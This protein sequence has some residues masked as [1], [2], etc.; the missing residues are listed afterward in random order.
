MGQGRRKRGLGPA[1]NDAFSQV[2]WRFAGGDSVSALRM[3]SGGMIFDQQ[4][5]LSVAF[6]DSPTKAFTSA[7]PSLLSEFT[8]VGVLFSAVDPLNPGGK[9]GPSGRQPFCVSVWA[10][11]RS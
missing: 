8:S 5:N 7:D 11:Y 9:T 2:S 3:E 1:Q 6:A 10:G 4:R